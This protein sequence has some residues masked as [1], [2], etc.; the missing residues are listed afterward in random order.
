MHQLGR[1]AVHYDWDAARPPALWIDSGD[2]VDLD[3]PSGE[4][5]QIGPGATAEDLVR[6]DWSRLHALVGPIAV[7]G[8][9]A[10]ETLQIDLLDLVP[11]AHG[12]V[13]HRPG[14]G[15]LESPAPYLRVLE[16]EG[17]TAHFGDLE[18]RI[19]PML[20]IVGV[21]PAESQ[22]STRPPGLHGGNLDCPRLRRGASLLLPVFF[23]GGLASFGDPHAMQGDGEV[24][25]TGLECAMKAQVRLIRREDIA[26][27]APVIEDADALHFLGHGATYTMAATMALQAAVQWL[28]DRFGFE[29]SDAYALASLT[30]DMGV[31]QLVNRPVVGAMATIR[32]D[33]FGFEGDLL[34]R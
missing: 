10:G 16:I 8:L 11:A 28:Q 17:D 1:P 30:V 18:L 34:R 15:V 20:G 9:L 27:S 21:V 32:K 23:D 4:D 3:L 6:L 5:D 25:V 26:V 13:L 22:A 2:I 7:R 33:R 19:S 24:C 14:V 31:P 29:F 12:F